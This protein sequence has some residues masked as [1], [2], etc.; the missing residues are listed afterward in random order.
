[1][2]EMDVCM[3]NVFMA[4]MYFFI[5]LEQKGIEEYPPTLAMKEYDKRVFQNEKCN[6]E[7]S[8]IE[9]GT[10]AVATYDVSTVRNLTLNMYL[11]HY[12]HTQLNFER[13]FLVVGTSIDKYFD[14]SS[15]L[16][17]AEDIVKIKWA[18]VSN[19]VRVN[20]KGISQWIESICQSR[21]YTPCSNDYFCHSVNDITCVKLHVAD[22]SD[23]EKIEDDF[24]KTF[25]FGTP[26]SYDEV[27]SDC[28]RFAYGLLKADSFY[29]AY[30][31][32]E[33]ASF[34]KNSY[35]YKE[36]ERMFASP[37]GTVFVR[38]HCP[39]KNPQ[40]KDKAVMSRSI[41]DVFNIKEFAS[42]IDT[43]QQIAELTEIKGNVGIENIN[44][45]IHRLNELLTD[46][47][48]K[49]EETY[50][51][52]RTLQN[53]MEIVCSAEIVKKSLELRMQNIKQELNRKQWEEN[54]KREKL[55]VLGLLLTV[56]ATYG[57]SF[58]TNSPIL[59]CCLLAIS[60]IMGIVYYVIV[61]KPIPYIA[62]DIMGNLKVGA[63]PEKYE[64][65]LQAISN[66]IDQM[67]DA[68][69]SIIINNL[70]H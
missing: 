8:P 31:E 51:K 38:T 20:Q 69:K 7:N 45:R 56:I 64:D 26:A 25:S 48:F 9:T 32:D 57:A 37:M 1:M 22:D 63:H 29:E 16:V 36:F 59:G 18:F 4:S 28:D 46:N 39:Y 70:K 58:L 14:D 44:S 24:A 50:K 67:I 35:Y 68:N 54:R 12:I 6:L 23:R 49:L 61:S 40:E 19:N 5:P 55:T 21:H 33:I 52:V 66:Q 11:V 65:S 42:L 15:Y 13:Y 10:H 47:P 17:T 34:I 2:A 62:F 43:Q 27:F 53:G 41:D 3:K 60:I 30:T